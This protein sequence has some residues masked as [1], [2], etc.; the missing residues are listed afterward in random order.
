MLILLLISS[1]SGWNY[2]KQNK[3]KLK[4]KFQLEHWDH[5]F[6]GPKPTAPTKR[7]HIAL[8]QWN[9]K[10][11][12]MQTCQ[13]GEGSELLFD[14][15]AK[16]QLLLLIQF[17]HFCNFFGFSG[18]T[19]P[20]LLDLTWIKAKVTS[21]WIILQMDRNK[22]SILHKENLMSYYQ[23][24]AKLRLKEHAGFYMKRRK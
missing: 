19:C 13:I 6:S 1:S 14:W 15:S 24:M 4:Y 12:C 21:R 23:N 11:K 3:N 20:L 18:I 22:S 9:K 17:A 2:K 7:V 8:H 5:N 16:C 10:I